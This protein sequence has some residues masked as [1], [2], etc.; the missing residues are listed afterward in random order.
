MKKV[1][2]KI[3]IGNV[4]GQL[5]VLNFD[6]KDVRYRKKYL[7]QCKCGNT[8]VILGAALVSGNTKSCG[9]LSKESKQKTRKPNNGSEITAIILGYKHH[10]KKRG[11]K[12]NLKREEVEY[13][14]KQNCHYCGIEPSNLKKTKNS[15]EGL[16]YNGIDRVD[17]LKDYTK[18]NCV[19]CCRTCNLAKRDMKIED[20]R[21]W[22][23]QLV[24]HVNKW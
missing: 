21:S 16:K 15:I 13:L 11:F 14:I 6:S 9:C 5:T 12:W 3:E 24:S 23:L 19:T 1:S 22:V 10:A 7:C 20:F 18:D 17:S 2:E 8:K 4:Y